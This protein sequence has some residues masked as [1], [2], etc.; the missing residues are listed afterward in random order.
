MT[1][2]LCARDTTY[3]VLNTMISHGENT[4]QVRIIQDI[5]ATSNGGSDPVGK[6]L[7]YST[8]LGKGFSL[9]CHISCLKAEGELGVVGGTISVQ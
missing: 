5:M 2:I 3:K 4:E 7:V 8:S 9:L 1:L 6:I